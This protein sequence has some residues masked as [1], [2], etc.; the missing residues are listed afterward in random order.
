MESIIDYIIY[1]AFH[2]FTKKSND[3]IKTY[4]NNEYMNR[5]SKERGG[6][7]GRRN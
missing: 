6:K 5:Y 1:N 2:F 3:N 4:E 7:S